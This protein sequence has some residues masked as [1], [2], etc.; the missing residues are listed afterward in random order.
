MVTIFLQRATRQGEQ[1]TKLLHF[2]SL[3]YS[4]IVASVSTVLDNS[5]ASH[6]VRLAGPADSDREATRIATV[7]ALEELASAAAGAVVVVSRQCLARA[8]NY[9]LDVAVRVASD[10]AVGALVL[11]GADRLPVTVKTLADRAGLSIYGTTGPSSMVDLVRRLD[12]LM[13]L[14]H[15]AVLERAADTVRWLR[16]SD[17]L[18]DASAILAGAG[19]RLGTSIGLSWFGSGPTSAE[20]VRLA[21]HAVGWVYGSCGEDQALGLVLPAVAAAIGRSYERRMAADEAAGDAIADLV[22]ADDL[23]RSAAAARAREVGV[24]VDARHVAVC[25][26][27]HAAGAPP[28]RTVLA[29]RHRRTIAALALREQTVAPTSSWTVA[30][31]DNDLI[32]VCS[33]LGTEEVKIERVVETAEQVLALLVREYPGVAIFAGIGSAGSGLEGLRDS[34]A[35]ASAAARSARRHGASGRILQVDGSRLEQVIGDLASSSISRKALDDLLAPLGALPERARATAIHTLGTYLD[36]QGSKVR[37]AAALHMHPNAIGYRIR[38]AV[39]ILGV[40]LTDPDTRLALQLSCRVWLM[41]NT[42]LVR[43]AQ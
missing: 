42:Q 12:L 18:A 26:F 35:Q 22:R 21:G 39:E 41:S 2:L 7:D 36:L 19:D 20:P 30:Q 27:A 31:V 25:L 4:F 17:G 33:S 32:L 5:G 14:G 23:S 13:G 24:H 37:A 34:A 29:L 43:A 6:F 40:D 1:S 16:D 8:A 3:S 28:S 10:R 38:K 11:P 9:E 15:A